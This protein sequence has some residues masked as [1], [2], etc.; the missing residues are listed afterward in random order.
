MVVAW[1][2]R[3]LAWVKTPARCRASGIA[4]A[5]APYSLASV[6]S[7]VATLPISRSVSLPLPLDIRSRVKPTV[8]FSIACTSCGV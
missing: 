4:P 2:A 3:K 8:S 1:V 7:L 5:A 6:G